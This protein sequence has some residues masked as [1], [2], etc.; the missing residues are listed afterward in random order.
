[1][2]RLVICYD[3]TWNAVT[4]PDEVTNV[5]RV[6]QAIKSVA[7]D[8]TT[9]VVYYNAGVGSGGPID[10]FV[11][12]VFGAGLRNNV[13]RGLA[14]LSL[15]WDPE[16]QPDNPVADEIYIFGF[17]RGAYSAR[18]LAGVI[19]AIGGIPRQASFDQLEKIW[20]HYRKTKE[21]RAQDDAEIKK[22]IYPMPP[23]K[24]LIIKC[25]GVWDTVGSYGVPAGLGLGALA[26]KFTSW[27][28]GFHDNEIGD[29]IEYGLHAM[30]IDEE[31]RAFP[32]TSWVT[33]KPEDRPGVEQ[34]WFA[35]AHSNVGG[36]YKESGLSDLALLWM[37]ARVAELTKLE[38]DN[39]YI[40]E[41]F[42]PCAACSLYRSNRG[43]LISSIW[44]FRRPVPAHLKAPVPGAERL[45]NAKVHWS[46]HQR[47]GKSALVDEK[48]YLK[49]APK[50]LP[51]EVDYTKR[52]EREDKLIAL[53]RDNKEHRKRGACALYREL[54]AEQGWLDRW[55]TRRLRRFREEWAK[56]PAT[57]I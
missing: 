5:V 50:N 43:W 55:R 9:Q 41:H 46:V 13:K 37:I 57:Q 28:R 3:G 36:G 42:W 54:P 52:T 15:N 10:R 25:V 31:R 26:R 12:G 27:T 8:G 1:M 30:A 7:D 44:P 40:Q 6:A 33:S 48:K 17:S 2:K 24:K 14:F 38:F 56:D 51:E 16:E 34:V 21:E 49:Y 4:N 32:A 39:D 47:H 19:G 45:I 18:A 29:Y 53:C 11:G 20:D 35:G 23:D 22:L